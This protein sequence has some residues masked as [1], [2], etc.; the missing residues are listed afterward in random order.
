MLDSIKKGRKVPEF[1]HFYE[2]AVDTLFKRKHFSH[3]NH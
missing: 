1:L 3:G 2:A